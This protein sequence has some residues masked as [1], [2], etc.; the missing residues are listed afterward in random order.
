MEQIKTDFWY[1][2]EITVTSFLPKVAQFETEILKQGGWDCGGIFF[3]PPVGWH[4]G[5]RQLYDEF[6]LPTRRYASN[7]NARL[8]IG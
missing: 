2:L 4:V 1:P 5:S 8:S 3:F 7:S 6:L